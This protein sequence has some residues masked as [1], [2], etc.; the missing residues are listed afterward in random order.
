[1]KGMNWRTLGAMN[2]KRVWLCRVGRALAASVAPL[3][4]LA[5]G[6]GG[7]SPGGPAV[8]LTRTISLAGLTN[9]RTNVGVPSRLDHL[10]YDPVS[11]RLF[12][13]ALENGSLEVVD[14]GSGRRVQSIGG[15]SRPQGVACLPSRSCVAVACGGDGAL[16]VYD[17]LS[18]KELRTIE[19]GEDPD[20]IRYDARNDRVLVAYGSS[21][22]GGIVIYEAGTWSRVGDIR[23]DSHPESFQLEPE[24]ERIF[25]NLPKGVAA[26]EDGSV[27][28]TR[29]TD[30]RQTRIPLLGRAWNFPMAF[31]AV[32]ERL[33]IAS[34]RPAR[35]IEIDTCNNAVLAE[36]PCTDD[37]DDLFYDA[38]T[39]RV[40][41]IGG[42]FR[43]DLQEP[44]T[45]SPNS[46][47][48][49]TGAL[50]V[51]AVGRNGELTRLS[52]T[53]TAPH[54]RTGLFVPSRRAIYIAVPYRAGRDAEI[55]EYSV[56]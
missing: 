22:A 12:V 38:R 45:A 9:T 42:G 26:V 2:K 10:A 27:E 13:A 34:R 25:T 44:G 29:Q 39:G 54:A 55:R 28:I 21:D 17:A 14:L 52:T 32:H 5:A 53:P 37:S 48:G 4:L 15:L 23:F 43:P 11:K 19:V 41:V 51:F 3:W 49:E 50:D 18:L 7:L 31:D 30:R 35:L 33:F 40:L 16:H 6:C 24:G 46:P 20:N 56:D 1:M 36:A 8:S 47:P